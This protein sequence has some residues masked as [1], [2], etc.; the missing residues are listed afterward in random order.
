[1][2]RLL[3]ATAALGA[4]AFPALAQQQ[5]SQPSQ[6]QQSEQSMP[7]SSSQSSQPS[8]ANERISPHSLKQSQIEELQQ[9][10]NDKGFDVGKVDGKWGP[11]TQAALRNFQQK[12]GMTSSGELDTNTVQALGLDVNQFASGESSTTTGSGGSQTIP[13]VPKNSPNG[14]QMNK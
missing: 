4:L 10:L 1:M 13:S 5:P 12:Q 3:L 8:Q 11:E 6:P 7:S 9:A 14:S 2:K